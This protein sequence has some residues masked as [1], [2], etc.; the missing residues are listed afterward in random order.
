MLHL[1]RLEEAG[2]NHEKEAQ[3]ANDQKRVEELKKKYGA[4]AIDNLARMH[5][6]D[7]AAMVAREG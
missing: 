6:G 5:P 3:L 2:F 4:K 7:V 1:E